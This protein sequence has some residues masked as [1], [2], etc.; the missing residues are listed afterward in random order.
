M[1]KPTAKQQLE[2]LRKAAEALMNQYRKHR[3]I[4]LG[5][6]EDGRVFYHLEDVLGSLDDD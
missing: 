3:E 5:Y 4:D 2:N 1:T 6:D